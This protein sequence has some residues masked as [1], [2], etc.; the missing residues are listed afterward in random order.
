MTCD[1]SRCQHDRADI[2]CQPCRETIARLAK[3]CSA[4]PEMCSLSV[5]QPLAVLAKGGG[6]GAAGARH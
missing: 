4:N 1:I 5:S 6:I 3:I 2:L